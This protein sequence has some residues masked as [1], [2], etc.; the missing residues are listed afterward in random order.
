MWLSF[1][2]QLSEILFTDFKEA[3][4]HNEKLFQS[5]I[6]FLQIKLIKYIYI[7]KLDIF[8]IINYFPFS[9]SQLEAGF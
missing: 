4:L 7:M 2:Q 6:Q 3:L 9:Y 8:I 5:V 1:L